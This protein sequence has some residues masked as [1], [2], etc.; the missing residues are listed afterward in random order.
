M[1]DVLTRISYQQGGKAGP[2]LPPGVLEHIFSFAIARGGHHVR[3]KL[4]N[5]S[6][7]FRCI[8]F[9]SQLLWSDVT[10][11][12][13]YPTS[14]MVARSRSWWTNTPLRLHLDNS[15]LP[16]PAA[17][18][19]RTIPHT[20]LLLSS[21]GYIRSIIVE[22]KFASS[23]FLRVLN[24]QCFFPELERLVLSSAESESWGSL[25]L[26]FDHTFEHS[27]P[28]IDAPAL[29]R[30]RL[31][32]VPMFLEQSHNITDLRLCGR[33]R[34]S[35]FQARVW[36][37]WPVRM[38]HDLL[39]HNTSLTVLHLV[40]T[41]C[42]NTIEDWMSS[43]S[44]PLLEVLIVC[45]P[46]P[47]EPIWVLDTIDFPDT[48]YIGIHLGHKAPHAFS[49][50]EFY[51]T[52]GV[53]LRRRK[54]TAVTAVSSL[55][56]SGIL[57]S[58]G[59]RHAM[60]LPRFDDTEMYLHTNEISHVFYDMAPGAVDV[61]ASYETSWVPLENTWHAIYTGLSPHLKEHEIVT[62]EINAEYA[63]LMNQSLLTAS[64]FDMPI[65]ELRLW[66]LQSNQC[67]WCALVR[68]L[69]DWTAVTI[70]L[71]SEE[72]SMSDAVDDIS[73]A[74]ETDV[75]SA[76]ADDQASEE[77]FAREPSVDRSR[78]EIAT[79]NDI[80]EVMQ[81]LYPD[82]RRIVDCRNGYTWARR[83]TVD[84]LEDVHRECQISHR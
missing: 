35:S 77:S 82:V 30:V 49:L 25:P 1:L 33:T 14:F 27:V 36:N 56:L 47:V 15:N 58:D 70:D 48:T 9:A 55:S 69:H 11:L 50:D 41:L 39:S 22:H 6:R 21:L 83:H 65:E 79:V 13:T 66:S 57:L 54:F 52:L 76:T 80:N 23:Y 18:R 28:A 81:S 71:P 45:S 8:V 84:L 34:G 29:R 43:V 51:Y 17:A 42:A 37:Q 38:V 59:P 44:L 3:V 40:E 4:R 60:P 7:K 19:P 53:L 62:M 61:T 16:N 64:R 46:S 75:E 63:M 67:V 24:R 78:L 73:N 74:D 31:C 26:I 12:P 72:E 20:S 32:S 10:T 68:A 2:R 5:T